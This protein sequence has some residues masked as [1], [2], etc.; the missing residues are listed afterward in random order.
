M[1]TIV[2]RPRRMQSSLILAVA[3]GLAGVATVLGQP[4]YVAADPER[5]RDEIPASLKDPRYASYT[6]GRTQ[7]LL[8][9]VDATT[10][11][12]YGTTNND[13]SSVAPTT[14][15]TTAAPANSAAPAPS[16]NGTTAAPTPTLTPHHDNNNQTTVAPSISPNSNHTIVPTTPTTPSPTT[17]Y[18]PTPTP[19]TSNATTPSPTTPNHNTTTPAPS[20]LAPHSAA[21][22]QHPTA[23][24][25]VEPP[26]PTPTPPAPTPA[27]PP[28]PA[29]K[30]SLLRF[31]EKTL[32][33][34]I[35]FVLCLLAFGAI[36]QNRYRI[37]FFL[38]GV[39]YTILRMSCTHWILVKLRI[40]R[41]DT[42]NIDS[43]LN[44]ALFEN[45]DLMDQGLLMRE[46][47]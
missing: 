33:L 41:G 26:A 20:T 32:A 25:T 17:I 13:N 31:L 21:P 38:R 18:S 19:T 2:R 9:E 44:A 6:N 1:N 30:F 47:E 15:T 22:V 35:L 40:R 14:P 43:S 11:G 46:N 8:H 28:P 27:P 7:P 23:A 45:D 5:Q 12:R 4:V 3:V 42:T 36:M 24:P 10:T 29:P 16:N 34:C 39:W 37:Y